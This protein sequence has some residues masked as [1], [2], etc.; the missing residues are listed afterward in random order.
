MNIGIVYTVY[1]SSACN[2]CTLYDIL[3]CIYGKYIVRRPHRRALLVIFGEGCQDHKL[4]EV[5]T[6]HAFVYQHTITTGTTATDRLYHQHRFSPSIAPWEMKHPEKGLGPCVIKQMKGLFLLLHGFAASCYILLP[7]S[8]NECSE[9]FTIH[10]AGRM[11]SQQM[12]CL[13]HLQLSQSPASQ[14]WI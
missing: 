2:V 8:H 13:R 7:D 14:R 12:Q 5:R 4:N 3:N 1:T 9:V 10:A 11:Q 6:V